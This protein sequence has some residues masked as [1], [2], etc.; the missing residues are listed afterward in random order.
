MTNKAYELWKKY[1]FNMMNTE[2]VI[3]EL[4]QFSGINLI[5]EKTS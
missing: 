2:P 5:K 4:G 1:E 3:N